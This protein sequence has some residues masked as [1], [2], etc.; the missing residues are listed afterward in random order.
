MRHEAGAGSGA[1]RDF[2]WRTSALVLFMGGTP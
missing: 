1:L 2:G